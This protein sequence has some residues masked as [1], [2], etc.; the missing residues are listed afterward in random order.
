MVLLPIRVRKERAGIRSRSPTAS[1]PGRGPAANSQRSLQG[2]FGH[3]RVP[4]VFDGGD[5]N[6][7][8]IRQLGRVGFSAKR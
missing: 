3:D 8:N 7:R 2:T 5:A 6:G 4:F 1:T